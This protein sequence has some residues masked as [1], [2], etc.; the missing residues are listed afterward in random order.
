MNNWD[1]DYLQ[2]CK[3]ILSE[4]KEVEN[5]TYCVKEKVRVEHLVNQRVGFKV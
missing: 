1:K 5:R 3:R 2:L 4:G